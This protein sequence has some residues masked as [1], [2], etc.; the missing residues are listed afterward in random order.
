MRVFPV[1]GNF[2]VRHGKIFLRRRVI[3]RSS[4]EPTL[5]APLASVNNSGIAISQ[6]QRGWSNAPI[7]SVLKGRRKDPI[8][9][10]SRCIRRP[11]GTN[12]FALLDQPDTSYLANLRS[13][14]ATKSRQS[15]WLSPPLL[16]GQKND[17]KLFGHNRKCRPIITGVSFPSTN[18]SRLASSDRHFWC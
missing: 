13:R 16:F 14:F 4:G 6:P 2:L 7:A 1:R 9:I 17:G 8:A 11:F 18:M 12:G 15:S 3:H 10:D 5:R